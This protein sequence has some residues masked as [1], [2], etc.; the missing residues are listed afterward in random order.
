MGKT[1][2]K[3]IGHFCLPNRKGD[4]IDPKEMK[5]NEIYVVPAS[6]YLNTGITK[7]ED[8]TFAVYQFLGGL[9]GGNRFKGNENIKISEKTWYTF[10]KKLRE[11]QG[12]EPIEKPYFEEDT[13]EVMNSI[14]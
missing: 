3:E 1:E 10:I 2:F 8:G 13:A 7:N 11:V 6:A 12:L 4:I 14:F 9:P 5:E